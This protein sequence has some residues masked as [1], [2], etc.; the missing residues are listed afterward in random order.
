MDTLHDTLPQAG[1]SYIRD[2]QTGEP[3]PNIPPATQDASP[4]PAAIAGEGRPA[5]AQHQ[6]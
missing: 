3:I 2:P 6:E 4:S 1:G 5:D